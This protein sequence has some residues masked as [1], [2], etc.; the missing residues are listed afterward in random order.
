MSMILFVLHDSE[1]LND[2]LTAWEEAGVSGITIFKSTG[3]GRIHQE[4]GLRDDIPL[5]PDINDFFP[6]PE[7]LGRTI[8]TVVKDESLVDKVINATEKILGSLEK[9]NTGLLLVLPV[10]KSLGLKKEQYS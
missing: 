6:N 4:Q 3:I 1:K 2:I 7:H 9:P 8:F 10:T 5:M